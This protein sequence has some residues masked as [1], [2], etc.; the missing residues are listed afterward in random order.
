MLGI[1]SI[2]HFLVDFVC[3]WRLLGRFSGTEGWV[4]AALLYNFCAFALQMPLGILADR[5]GRNRVFAALGALL[6]C[7]GALVPGF[8]PSVLML[9]IGNAL[10]HVG[11][12]RETM[13]TSQGFAR[14]GIFVAPGAVGIFLGGLVRGN[15]S[16]GIPG[17]ASLLL[18]GILLAR[19]AAGEKPDCRNMAVPSARGLGAV[20]LVFL[21]VLLRSAVGMCAESPWKAGAWMWIG[22]ILG[23]GG[24][25]LG[26]IAADRFGVKRA[27]VFS[28]L[29][30]G[31]LFLFP[32]S[33]PAGAAAGLLFQM[34]MPITLGEAARQ[35]PGGE[36]FVFGLMTFA[37]FLGFLLTQ[38]NISF[39]PVMTAL[40]AVLSGLLLA[41]E[42]RLLCNT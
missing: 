2:G 7:L 24:K 31:V 27:G 16:Y 32:N 30:S 1:Y 10:Y 20:V 29:A 14:L 9:G 38:W 35:I 18:V 28:L 15:P 5:Y 22:A 37:L 11:G 4:L 40:L 42:G 8:W 41:L 26:G 6:V 13:L 21:V 17:M 36:G 33:A 3:A 23:A 25:A 34:S 39:P 19:A 12:G